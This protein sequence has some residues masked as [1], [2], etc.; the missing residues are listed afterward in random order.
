MT[1]VPRRRA[2]RTEHC[3]EQGLRGRPEPGPR[4]LFWLVGREGA[5]RRLDDAR[6]CLTRYSV[7]LRVSTHVLP[8]LL[9]GRLQEQLL[10]L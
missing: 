5:I 1:S 7:G 9:P 4:E 2:P 6:V 8:R 10:D 3:P